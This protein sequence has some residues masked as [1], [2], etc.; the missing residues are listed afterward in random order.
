MKTKRNL[1][2]ILVKNFK[3]TKVASRDII[4]TI[5][6][7]IS[8]GIAE[9]KGFKINNFGTFSTKILC[10]RLGRNP[11]TNEKIAIPLRKKVKFKA[12]KALNNLLIKK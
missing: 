5:F 10:E 4:D 7:E 3:L 11:K 2:E 8:K 6:N 12:Y 1:I 9:E